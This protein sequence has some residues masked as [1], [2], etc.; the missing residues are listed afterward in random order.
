MRMILDKI[1]VQGLLSGCSSGCSHADFSILSSY[2]FSIFNILG[3]DNIVSYS[4][5]RAERD[6]RYM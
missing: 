5:T 6:M 3:E 1:D 4:G 2:R